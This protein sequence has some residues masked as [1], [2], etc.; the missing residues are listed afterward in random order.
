MKNENKMELFM[1]NNGF[2][3]V[4]AN[5]E[6]IQDSWTIRILGDK[7]EAFQDLSTEKYNRYVC[8]NNTEENLF[9]IVDTINELQ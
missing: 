2:K 5:E 6:Y 3:T 9:L 4:K 8:L 7:I 1:H